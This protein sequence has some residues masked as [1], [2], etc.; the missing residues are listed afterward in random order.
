MDEFGRNRTLVSALK[1][2]NGCKQQRTLEVHFALKERN[3]IENCIACMLVSG[4]FLR[5]SPTCGNV[6]CPWFGEEKL[7]CLHVGAYFG[8][9][10]TQSFAESKTIPARVRSP[11]Y[12][13]RHA[14]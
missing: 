12:V 13:Y 4:N 7:E 10:R 2:V 5:G 3:K 8:I 9:H 11:A 14:Q 1:V 6:T